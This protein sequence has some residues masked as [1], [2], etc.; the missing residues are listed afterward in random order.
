MAEAWHAARTLR[1]L[2][3]LAFQPLSAPQLADALGAHPP[4]VRRVAERM[5]GE[6]VTSA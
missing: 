4:T 5:V 1:I 2:E 3:L 6:V